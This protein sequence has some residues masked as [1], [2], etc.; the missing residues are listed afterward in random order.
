MWQNKSSRGLSTLLLGWSAL[1]R[2][3][4]HLLGV[5]LRWVLRLVW[6]KRGLVLVSGLMN[7]MLLFLNEVMDKGNANDRFACEAL[8]AETCAER[9]GDEDLLRFYAQRVKKYETTDAPLVYLANVTEALHLSHALTKKANPD[10]T[11]KHKTYFDL[12]TVEN[13]VRLSAHWNLN[14]PYGKV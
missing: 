13:H 10:A 4:Q 1:R 8:V 11:V 14:A 6:D 12:K 9:G 2:L 5:R 3:G 7:E